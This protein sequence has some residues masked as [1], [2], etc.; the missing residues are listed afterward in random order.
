LAILDVAALRDGQP[1]SFA[2][3]LRATQVIYRFKKV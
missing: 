2:P 1:V 3:G